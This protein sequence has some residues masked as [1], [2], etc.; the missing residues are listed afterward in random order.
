MG[1]EQPRQRRDG[2]VPPDGPGSASEDGE[3]YECRNQWWNPLK[4][5]TGSNLVDLG[6]YCSVAVASGNEETDFGADVA[7]VVRGSRRRSAA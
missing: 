1:W 3:V 6:R 4:S 2:P 7:K 5:G